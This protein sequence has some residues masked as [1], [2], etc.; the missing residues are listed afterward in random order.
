MAGYR[1]G[2]LAA[3]AAVASLALTGCGGSST[4][5]GGYGS[6][7]VTGAKG[8]MSLKPVVENTLTVETNL[9]SPGWWKG[10][11]PEG[12][13]G[14][15][16]YCLAANIAYRAGLD[17]V[18]V[19]NASFDALVAGQTK[20]Y[21]IAMAQVSI[22][23]AREKVVQFSKPY[24]DSNVAVLVKEGAGV[25][26]SNIAS[27]KLGVALGTTAVDFVKNKI[28]PATPARV[29]QDTDTMV[30]AV[31]SGQIDAAI[32]DT[33][34]LLGFAKGSSGAMT[35]IGQYK[36]GEQYGAIYPK[37]SPNAGAMNQAI[38]AMSADGTLDKLSA[39]WLGPT[40]GGDPAKVPAFPIP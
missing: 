37:D 18:K 9:P 15:Y 36:T 23:P 3:V 6:C 19:V 39:T 31:A 32:Q 1:F 17:H 5:A 33:A 35:V 14:G 13:D 29:F 10:L 34:T 25:T 40:L 28:N 2:T 38:D 11:S 4:A 27:K 16:E 24:F 22:T 26:A 12:I 20:D 7:E 8:S 30:T 21:D